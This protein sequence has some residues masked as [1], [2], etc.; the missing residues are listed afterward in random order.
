M[1][2]QE[3]VAAIA[4]DLRGGGVHVQEAAS[5]GDEQHAVRR[6]LGQELILLG[7]AAQGIDRRLQVELEPALSGQSPPVPRAP[8]G[9]RRASLL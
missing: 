6:L 2:L 7:A 5:R 3:L 1:D 4:Q 8:E 9:G